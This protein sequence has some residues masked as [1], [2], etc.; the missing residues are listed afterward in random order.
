LRSGRCHPRQIGPTLHRSDGRKVADR[1]RG[2][3]RKQPRLEYLFNDFS[4][5]YFKYLWNTVVISSEPMK[6]LAGVFGCNAAITIPIPRKRVRVSQIKL[7]L[8]C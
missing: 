7:A 2:A 5:K 8:H 4:F 3:R 6:S 1:D